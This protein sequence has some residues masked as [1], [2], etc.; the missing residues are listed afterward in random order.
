MGFFDWLRPTAVASSRQTPEAVFAACL[1]EQG[2]ARWNKADIAGVFTFG[3]IRS[4]E[5]IEDMI[6]AK[7]LVP[8]DS[9]MVEVPCHVFVAPI[10]TLTGWRV[11]AKRGMGQTGPSKLV[12]GTINL[13]VGDVVQVHLDADPMLDADMFPR[14]PDG[15]TASMFGKFL[16]AHGYQMGDLYYLR[17]AT[18]TI[19]YT[20]AGISW[21]IV[22]TIWS[23]IVAGVASLA[24]AFGEFGYL[25]A[26][27]RHASFS[28]SGWAIGAGAAVFV[29]ALYRSYAIW[30]RRRGTSVWR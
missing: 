30:L 10:K 18:S 12:K 13:Q 21:A 29:W 19:S 22:S 24:W 9:C 2:T 25:Y 11:A 16:P 5:F 14:T 23:L 17:W 27:R 8:R 4:I 7:L 28:I 15:W 3:V 1:R 26:T 6:Q 20:S